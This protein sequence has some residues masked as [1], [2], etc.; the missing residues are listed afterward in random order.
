MESN[1]LSGIHPN[2]V[3]FP[4]ALFVTYSVLEIIGIIFKK[5][6]ISKCALL[7]LCIGVVTALIAVL[8]GNLAFEQFG[9]WS[10]E[11]KYLLNEHQSFATY[12]LW[13]SF[14]ICIARI[15]LTIKKKFF[16]LAKYLFI[17]LALLLIFL[18]YETGIRGGNLVK[19]FGIGTELVNSSESE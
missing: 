16:G 12:L 1:F 9:S 2:V 15:Y 14:L 19:K 17:L 7:L 11:S 3:H 13:S 4:I 10:K 6:F 18:V 5:D 8:T